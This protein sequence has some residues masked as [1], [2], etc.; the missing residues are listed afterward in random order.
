MYSLDKI[1]NFSAFVAP[2]LAATTD[3][4][5]QQYRSFHFVKNQSFC[6]EVQIYV[7]IKTTDRV[8]MPFG[9]LITKA[10]HAIRFPKQNT[11][12]LSVPLKP[13]EKIVNDEIDRSSLS[14]GSGMRIGTYTNTISRKILYYTNTICKAY[15]IIIDVINV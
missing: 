12:C 5:I 6:D 10:N 7:R 2:Y 9:P 15:N 14:F 4:H 8:W 3:L 1:A 13:S 11:S